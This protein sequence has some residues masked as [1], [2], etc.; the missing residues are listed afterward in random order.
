[1]GRK[2]SYGKQLFAL[3]ENSSA[4]VMECRSARVMEWRYGKMGF[5]HME[6]MH[7]TRAIERLG[8]NPP[9]R[10]PRIT[11]S[12][13]RALA[14]AIEELQGLINAGWRA[15]DL[16]YELRR[17]GVPVAPA[18]VRTARYI[19]ASSRVAL[20]DVQCMCD[21]KVVSALREIAALPAPRRYAKP[22]QLRALKPEL[23]AL[24]KK[25]VR[26]QEIVLA[27]REDGLNTT[28]GR[29]REALYRPPRSKP[30]TDADPSRPGSGP[31]T[32]IQADDVHR[33]VE[34]KQ[35]VPAKLVPG[36]ARQISLF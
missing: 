35:G 17:R 25:G 23:R 29:L 7:H 27:L 9:Q 19:R 11:R 36:A 18:T 24:T 34:F 16:S 21:K 26:L 1:M 4:R 8:L 10:R 15:D 2:P 28:V 31:V 30:K 22:D 20:G 32:K 12:Y 6:R 33:P 14:A 13:T 5:V 3:V